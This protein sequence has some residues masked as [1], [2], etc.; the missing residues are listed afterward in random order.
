MAELWAIDD[1]LYLLALKHSYANIILETDSCQEIDLL[2]NKSTSNTLLFTLFLNCRRLLKR[3]LTVV[4]QS[5]FREVNQVTDRYSSQELMLI[6]KRM[7]LLFYD[8]RLILLYVNLLQ[9]VF[10]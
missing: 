3:E 5:V 2:R 6:I 9:F 7:F 10:V 1:G 8:L 4:I